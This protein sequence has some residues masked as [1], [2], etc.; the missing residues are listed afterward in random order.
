MRYILNTV[1]I[2][3]KAAILEADKV[4]LTFFGHSGSNHST[5][6]LHRATSANLSNNPSVICVPRHKRGVANVG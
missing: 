2:I 5:V 6:Y 1:G 3:V 4:K